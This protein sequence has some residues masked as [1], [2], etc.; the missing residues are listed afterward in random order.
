MSPAE[1]EE[2]AIEVPEG[3]VPGYLAAPPDAP[4]VVVFAHGSGSSR[5]SPRN[6]F[7]AE[8]LREHGLATLLI[9]LATEDEDPGPRDRFDLDVATRRLVAAVDW[10]TGPDGWEAVGLVGSSTGAAAALCA[11]VE[12]EEAVRALVSRGGRVDLADGVLPDVQA[13][14]RLIV[15]GDDRRVLDANWAGA[16]AMPAE[17]DLHVVEDAGHLFEGPGE[18][19]EVAEVTAEWFARHLPGLARPRSA[20]TW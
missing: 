19:G 20:G 11:S 15:G 5:E 7:V 14:T 8:M 1:I 6:N 10:V 17:V 9:D 18:L 3:T 4:G 12:R 13:P 16:A 2:V